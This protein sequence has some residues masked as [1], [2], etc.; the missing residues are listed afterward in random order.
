MK[1]FFLILLTVILLFNTY[2]Y[3]QPIDINGEAALMVDAESTRILYEKNAHK[4]MY[5][6][7]TTKIM[8]AI[9]AIEYGK[10]DEMVLADEEVIRLTSGSHIALDYDELVRF[11]DLL[12]AL[13]IPSGNDAA[14]ALG[15]H[16]SGSL[17]GF[18]EAMNKKAKEIGALNTNFT[19]PH[20]LHDDNHYTTAYDLYLIT[21][22]AMKYDLFREIVFKSTYRIPPTNKKPLE[23]IMHSTNKFLH[24]NEKIY[25][26]GKLVPIEYEG[27][28][29]VKTGFTNQAGRCF[30]G[31]SKKNG[32]GIYTV[33]LNAEGSEVFADTIK[34]MDYG[35]NTF[36]T[37]PIGHGNEFIDNINIINGSLPYASA[38]LEKDIYYT[39]SDNE[40]SGIERKVRINDEIIAPIS[41][42]DILGAVE[43]YL[44][45]KL[46]AEANIISTISV[47]LVTSIKL[48]SFLLQRWYLGLF[49]LFGI[50]LIYRVYVISKKNIRRKRS[51]VNFYR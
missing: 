14:L 31:F 1:R 9:L 16:I 44:D 13:L 42:G 34:L 39:L 49:A 21:N 2:V 15:K 19:N 51:R 28:A 35:F 37:S 24:G 41:K 5:P 45:G 12:N 29:G 43:Y 33:V 22:Y 30:V 25:V 7:S 47:D 48:F 26:N 50:W 18:I 38:V 10:M 27:I 6:A 8:T 20:G 46:I 36:T 4:K 3:A 17:D 11:E 32:R 23:R 40:T